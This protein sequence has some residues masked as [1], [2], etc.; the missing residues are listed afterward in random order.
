MTTYFPESIKPASG[1]EP[2]ERRAKRRL[3]RKAMR[4][5]ARAILSQQ[6]YTIGD[7]L[8]IPRANAFEAV[9]NGKS[10][11]VGIRSSADRWVALTQPALAPGGELAV[12]DYLYVITFSDPKTRD[13]VQ[14]WQFDGP[15]VADMGKQIFEASG[16]SG[17]QWLPLDDAQDVDVPSM[18]AG[19]LAKR[20][21]LIAEEKVEWSDKSE[22]MISSDI[23]DDE[24]DKSGPPFRL[25][26]GQA[27]TGL[28]RQF[29]VS[30]DSIKITIEG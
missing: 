2:A 17:Q 5:R 4:Q 29:G 24:E 1:E 13:T 8:G 18:K 7:S 22:P 25:T 9:Q 12:V 26:I 30:T 21:K 10:V 11:K 23:D 16:K 15:V 28:A 3:L 6:G 20:G 19:S 27:K 14:L